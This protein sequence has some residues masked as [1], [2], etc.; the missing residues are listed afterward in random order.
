MSAHDHW[1]GLDARVCVVS[2]AAG[3]IGRAIARV[4]AQA[5]GRVAMLDLDQ[6]RCDEAAAAL[7][8][9]G[10]DAL[11][12]QCDISDPDSVRHAESVVERQW[13]VADVLVNNAGLLRPAGIEAIDLEA[14]NATLAVNLTGYMLSSQAFGRGM[15]ARGSGSIVHVSSVAA[16]SPQT[17]SGAYSAS[18]AAISMLSRQLAA[19]WGARGVRSNS[20]CPGL[21]R[22]PLSAAF[23]ARPEI[24]AGRRAMTASRRIGEPEDIAH[25]VAFLASARSAYVNGA[26]LSVDGGLNSMLM[27]LVPRPGFTAADAPDA[28]DAKAHTARVA[29][30]A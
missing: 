20:V 30:A 22:T 18:K 26:E 28:P 29:A 24:E 17:W 2:G 23:Y 13:G 14:W 21:I 19:E 5:G 4:L 7:R 10:H 1:L 9:D 25:V 3:G 16:L 8:A 6:T 15:L 27:D 12:V 11:G